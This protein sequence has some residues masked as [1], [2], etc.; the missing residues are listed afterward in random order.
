MFKMKTLTQLC[1]FLALALFLSGCSNE[2]PTPTGPAD[3]A[4]Q[5]VVNSG[6]IE[7]D[8]QGGKTELRFNMNGGSWTAKVGND[9]EESTA[10]CSTDV[11]TDG[12]KTIVTVSAQPNP[13]I[14]GR[15]T[16]VLL[17]SD[18]QTH[19]INVMQKPTPQFEIVNSHVDVPGAGGKVFVTL[20]TNTI[21]K[22]VIAKDTPWLTFVST[23]RRGGN[24]KANGVMY[25]IYQF[26]AEKNTDLGRLA[27]ISFLLDNGKGKTADVHQWSRTLHATENIH[28]DKPGQL[29]I[30]LG[31]NANDWANIENLK[32]SGTLNVTDMQVLRTLL[33]PE[34]RFTE[35]N[36]EGNV[37]VEYS[38]QLNVKQ[39]DM[40]DCKL[41]AGGHEYI[42]ENIGRSYEKRYNVTRDNELGEDAFL[43]TRTPLES[44]V[45]PA[46]LQHIG[47][48]A[49]CFC[50]HL[51]GIDIP[52]SVRT[53]DERAFWNCES[54]KR[55]A[56][57][58]NSQLE[59]L[60]YMALSTPQ[61]LDEIR[62]PATLQVDTKYLPILGGVR[63]RKIHLKW[64][65]P[66]TLNRGKVSSKS[67]LYVPQGTAKSYRE[68]NGWNKAAEVIEE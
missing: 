15:K 60:G 27:S 14:S 16:T 64:T 67:I 21:V 50:E 56:I 45:L 9:T 6:L 66:P 42:E 58:D 55:I 46:G 37:S 49:F 68:A 13:G 47:R 57:P 4:T 20:R 61:K 2:D 19:K 34:V 38:V 59:T 32:L 39:V 18:T 65:T 1:L 33:K 41:V 17:S 5:Q 40:G 25:L 12:Q 63:A 54:L 48:Q 52:A 62:F 24:P 22:P 30:L 43:I 44:I 26:N 23:E 36:A 31:A 11:Q 35:R 8:N 10:W 29:G 3:E 28:V 53:I 51:Q 7:F